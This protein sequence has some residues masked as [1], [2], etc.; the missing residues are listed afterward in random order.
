MEQRLPPGGR[1]F[2]INDSLVFLVSRAGRPVACSSPY[3]PCSEVMSMRSSNTR[4]VMKSSLT[5]AMALLVGVSLAPSCSSGGGG[6]G[7]KD[8]GGS[9]GGEDTGGKPGTGGDKGDT[10]GK[11]G[12]TGGSG[13][14]GGKPGTGGSMSTGGSM[15]TGGAMDTGG[16]MGTGGAMGTGGMV[17]EGNG[18][19]TDMP[20][21]TPPAL[22]KGMMVTG[23]S[24]QAG[25]VIGAPDDPT[26]MYVIGHANGNVYVVKDFKVAGTLLNVKVAGNGNGPEQGL[27]GIA[28]HPQFKTNHLMYVLYTAAGS[29]D[30]T[31]DEFE[32]T[33]PT[34]ATFKQNVHQHKG[35]NMYH[36]GGQI[37]FSPKDDKPLLYHSVGN[38]Q[39]PANSASP[40]S[41]NG[42]VLRYDV[43]TKMGVPA[44]GG[45][46]MT[47]AYGLR[48][49]YRMSVD[50][51]TGD[52]WIGDV[53]DGPGGAVFFMG[54]DSMVQN[55]GYGGGGE[56]K[57]GIS[58]F[59]GGNAAL[60][61]GVVY[62]G[63]KIKGICGRYFFGM[64]TNGAIKSIA[65]MGGTRMGAVADHPALSV[66]GQLSSFGEDTE[67]E[68]WMS[69][70]S[71]NA[72]YRIEAM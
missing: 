2:E 10:G 46:M 26:I 47:F 53:S 27:L 30:I 42:K 31:V 55:F 25:Q 16:S 45:Q 35:S 9:G 61:G 57:G 49:P 24:G 52:V 32:R 5:A 15:G 40:T 71:N 13:D 19:C 51:L 6:G 44:M 29:G 36:N 34:M 38:A 58:G 18:P 60:I 4:N 11:P 63:N 64:H 22:K 69:S 17:S 20:D 70:R 50:R 59:Q 65:Q 28:M 14:T 62:R 12:N 43:S 7:G 1:W 37:Y 3:W 39:S 66:P 72:I 48:N 41:L 8:T 33:T 56:V 23:F 68:I 54:H 21:A 67:G